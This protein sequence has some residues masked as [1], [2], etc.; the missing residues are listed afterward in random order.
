M[1]CALGLSNSSSPPPSAL[2]FNTPQHFNKFGR[3]HSFR[4]VFLF[5]LLKDSNVLMEETVPI[6]RRYSFFRWDDRMVVLLLLLLLLAVI[7]LS[8]VDDNVED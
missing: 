6:A 8:E 5:T 1:R 3:E 2:L 7:V 4:Y